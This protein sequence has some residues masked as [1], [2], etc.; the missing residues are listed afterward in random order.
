MPKKGRRSSKKTQPYNLTPTQVKKLREAGESLLPYDGKPV[1][2][3]LANEIALAFQNITPTSTPGTPTPAEA[4][5]LNADA[6]KLKA[7]MKTS[8]DK[9][10][11]IKPKIGYGPLDTGKYLYE[12]F[13]AGYKGENPADAAEYV[14]G[15]HRPARGIYEKHM[16]ANGNAEWSEEDYKDF[17]SDLLQTLHKGKCWNIIKKGIKTHECQAQSEDARAYMNRRRSEFEP[18]EFLVTCKG[19]TIDLKDARE[20]ANQSTVVGMRNKTD[21]RLLHTEI[22][23]EDAWDA[24]ATF[25]RIKTAML[26]NEETNARLMQPATQS[27][28][29]PFNS[30]PPL[31]NQPI[32]DAINEIKTDMQDK[33]QQEPPIPQEAAILAAVIGL[34]NEIRKNNNGPR[35]YSCGEQGHIAKECNGKCV[36]C[37]EDRGDHTKDCPSHPS[38]VADRIRNR[39]RNRNRDRDRESDRDSDRKRRRDQDRDDDKDRRGRARGGSGKRPNGKHGR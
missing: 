22:Q 37:G 17:T 29:A 12:V 21:S 8:A 35:C 5:R 14:A 27:Y 20:R 9:R 38:R 2:R 3:N 24:E 26:A 10:R 18:F 39:D 34:K 7:A 15:H 23:R 1:T 33:I 31:P 13:D 30:A 25:E 6:T 32:L 4:A 36:K 28:G 19:S 16:T 11:N